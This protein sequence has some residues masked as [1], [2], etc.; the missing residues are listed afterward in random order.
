MIET[1]CVL[2][3]TRDT[4]FI[5]AVYSKSKSSFSVGLQTFARTWFPTIS[6]IINKFDST[7]LYSALV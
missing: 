6:Y 4:W 5:F 7:Q 2:E 1:K 3:L